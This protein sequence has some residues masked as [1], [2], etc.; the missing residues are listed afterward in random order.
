M[1]LSAPFIH[2][3]IMTTF[4]MVAI[5]I[6]GWVSFTRLPVSD[7]PVIEQPEIEVLAGY[8]GAGPE[9][10]L[11]QLTIPL[12]KELAYVKGVQEISSVSSAGHTSIS[13]K[14]DLNKQMDQAIRDVQAAISRAEGHMPRDLSP[15]PYYRR[16]QGSQE[17]V[18]YM[19]LTSK[20]VSLGDLR[21]Y[22]DAFIIP[23][24]SRLEGVAQISAFGEKRSIWI[25]VNPELMAARRIGFNQVIDSIAQYSKQMPMGMIQTGNKS[26]AIELSGGFSQIS[27]LENIDIGHTGVKLKDFSEVSEKAS[28]NVDFHYLNGGERSV[29]LILGVQKISDANTVAVSKGVKVVLEQLRKELPATV[30]LDVWFDKAVW[31]HESILDVEW[32]LLFAFVLVVG[33]IYLSLGRLSEALIP[34][35]AL[36]L[37]LVGTFT[38]MYVLDYSLDLLSLLALTLSVGFVV[39]DAIVVLENIVRH[40]ELGENPREAS[41][42]GSKQICFTVVSMTL[43]LIAVFI[44]LLF[45]PGMTGRLFREFSVTL[46]V[47]ILVSGFISLT[48]TPMLCSRF[49]PKHVHP[50]RLQKG[51]HALNSR[52]ASFYGAT[53]KWCLRYSKTTLLVAALCVAATVPLF[54][55]L[56]VRLV[57]PEDRGLFFTVINLPTGIS[58]E[59]I[60]RY[61]H[62]LE[63]IFQKNP[64]VESL[65]DIYYSGRFVLAVNLKPTA[66]RPPQKEVIDSL[67]K[68]LGEIPGIVAFTQG[69]NL[70]NIDLDFGSEGQYQYIVKGLDFDEV[71]K[72]ALELAQKL[73]QL[74]EISYVQPPKKNDAPKLI[75]N[76]NEEK[77]NRLGLT[78][79]QVQSLL[80][81]AYGQSEVAVLHK[82]TT[83]EKVY[84]ELQKD[85]QSNLD[86]L[87]KIYLSPSVGELVPLKALADWS[88]ALGAP[89]RVRREQ[90]PSTS[91][92][93]SLH[94][95]VPLQQGLRSVEEVAA[96]LLPASVTGSFSGS[97]LAVTSTTQ[98]TLFLLLAASIVMYVVLGILYESFIHPLTILSSLPF[99]SLGGV[100]TLFLF[101]EPLSIFSAVGFL[102]LIGIVKKNG[103]MMVDYAL[104]NQ[105]LGMSAEKAI[106]EGCLVRFRPIMMTTIAAIMGAIPIA[107]G[108]GDGAETR[109]GLGL[110]IVGGLLFAQV[111]TL[112]VTPVIYLAF[113]KLFRSRSKENAISSN[114]SL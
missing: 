33:V 11:N 24:L 38:A 40:Q 81:N 79:H 87:S 5:L 4:V 113:E 25:R 28:S 96:Q 91:I 83:T 45:M 93:V 18:M 43:S 69:Y 34:S 36:P 112:Y 77:A 86:G 97:A 104:E 26:L 42:K 19:L 92:S 55:Q 9:T 70:I 20:T 21:N 39:D 16:Q 59:E 32:S 73:Q 41:L 72:S 47:S 31:I 23:R 108:F 30:D 6:A 7:L 29:A 94:D 58:R 100:L 54:M 89:N 67:S 46:A 63:S 75:L 10:I 15:R 111:L 103:I 37:S 110:V 99:A 82:G 8:V 109:R 65:L 80:Q 84:L 27:Q 88:E 76:I 52:M 13:L 71:D 56:P 78:R 102:L 74:P 107:I 64:H 105:R 61:Q 12:E 57:P 35:V 66:E 49:L 114:S 101:E 90:L 48:L 44:P 85:Y 68:E 17:P 1:N 53:L 62:R 95:G 2:R 98:N 3:P 50:T 14:F 106:F 60:K 22:A 51:V